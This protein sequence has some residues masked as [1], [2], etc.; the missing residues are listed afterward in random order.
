[1]GFD[2]LKEIDKIVKYSKVASIRQRQLEQN[3]LMRKEYIDQ[4]NKMT[5]M[6][7]LERLKEL[8]YNEEQKAIKK[9]LLKL[10][11]LVI[12]DQIKDKEIER[13]RQK[14][15]QEKERQMMLRQ[16][17]ELE[18]EEKRNHE[19]KKLQTERMTVETMLANKKAAELKEQ[20]KFEE[21]E[22]DLKMIQYNMEKA[23]KEEDELAEKK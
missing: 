12:N 3:E 22:L 10:G 11:S 1:M 9:E 18:E 5:E 23:K 20:K 16:I 7:E 15:H 4:N 8:K 13:I 21:L 6:M 17:K 2:E 19:M 14:E